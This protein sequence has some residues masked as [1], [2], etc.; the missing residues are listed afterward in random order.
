MLLSSIVSVVICIVLA[1]GF[2]LFIRAAIVAQDS[3]N[4]EK[5]KL[6][7]K[8]CSG[9]EHY[10]ERHKRRER[11]LLNRICCDCEYYRKNKGC[12]LK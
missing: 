5:K 8:Y 9:C 6:R 12:K 7:D 1:V 2:I 3:A 11:Q 10:E 4:R